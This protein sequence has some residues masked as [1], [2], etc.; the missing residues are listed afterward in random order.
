METV[1]ELRGQVERL[2]KTVKD[3]STEIQY[4]KDARSTDVAAVAQVVNER[5]NQQLPIKNPTDGRVVLL[6]KRL[7]QESAYILYL[8]EQLGSF[9][10]FNDL[11]REKREGY[12]KRIDA[13]VEGG[14]SDPGRF[15]D[16][17]GN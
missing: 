9:T 16:P 11:S 12:F 1:E 2:K 13:Q 4:L 6:A 3:M 8:E 7:R 14:R 15:T 5:I 10:P 17:Y